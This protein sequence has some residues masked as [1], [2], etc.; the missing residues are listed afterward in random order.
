M[1]LTKEKLD[2]MRNKAAQTKPNWIKVGMSTCGIAAG[3]KEVYDTLLSEKEKHKLDIAVDKCGCAG[4]CSVEP[5]VEVRI[6][7]MPQVIYGRV[8]KE[9]ALEIIDKHVISR[10]LLD[11][12]IYG[13]KAD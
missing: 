9:V 13:I 12:H 4:M 11:D 2:Q 10:R 7:G 3:A 6:E 8:D 5:L 1:K